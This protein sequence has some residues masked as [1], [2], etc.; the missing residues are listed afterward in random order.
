MSGAFGLQIKEQDLINLFID[1]PGQ[2]LVLK[3][4]QQMSTVP[5]LAKLFGPLTIGPI[6]NGSAV[7]QQQKWADYERW[8]WSMRQLPAISV[9]EAET[10]DKTSRNAWL[11]GTINFQ[12][13]WPAS[14]RR[15]DWSRIPVAF[16]GAMQNFFESA[17]TNSM[18]DEIY[19][20]VRPQKV[21]GLN[22][23]GKIM[24]FTPNLEGI[25][26]KEKVPVTLV[27]AKYRI[28]LR[29]WYRYLNFDNRTQDQP[30]TRTLA[31][32]TQLGGEYDGVLAPGGDSQIAI[33]D[34]IDVSST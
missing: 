20:H 25:V 1:A 13:V 34:E 24:T 33:P 26:E 17:Y 2:F 15:S 28:D 32:L 10:E 18:L 22:E 11:N 21:P 8:D 5:G 6:E 27:S 29:A 9:F 31:D 14:F 12:V 4:L 30:F 7:G 16:K 3:T 23:Y 19:W